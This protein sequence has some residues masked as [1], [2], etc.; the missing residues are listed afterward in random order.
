[1]ND[2]RQTTHTTKYVV[3]IL[4]TLAGLLLMW[5]FRDIVGYVIASAVL[6]IVGSPLV[7]LVKR[8]QP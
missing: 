1:M 7:G 5:Y 2:G 8:V 4:A 3:G 6:A